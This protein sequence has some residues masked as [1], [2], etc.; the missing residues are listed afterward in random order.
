MH[1]LMSVDRQGGQYVGSL[2][3]PDDPAGIEFWGVLELVAALETLVELDP[4]LAQR[5]PP[6]DSAWGR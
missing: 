3:R 5:E 1:L 6:G 4:R 2:R